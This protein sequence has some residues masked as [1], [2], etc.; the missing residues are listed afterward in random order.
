MANK[1][2]V[3]INIGFSVVHT[4]SICHIDRGVVDGLQK[5]ENNA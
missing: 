1:T 2:E 3:V 5:A 4:V